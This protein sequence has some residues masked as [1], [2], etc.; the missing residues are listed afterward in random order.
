MHIQLIN[1]I[2]KEILEF[3]NTN[4]MNIAN[5]AQQYEFKTVEEV[6]EIENFEKNVLI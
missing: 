6:V 1:Y 5:N 3:V 2:T 4:S